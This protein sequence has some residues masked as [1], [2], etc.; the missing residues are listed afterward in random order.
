MHRIIIKMSNEPLLILNTNIML[1]FTHV[2]YRFIDDEKLK[3]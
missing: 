2:N 1:Q 3:F